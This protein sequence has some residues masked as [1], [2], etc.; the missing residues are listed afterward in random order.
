MN[1]GFLTICVDK[2]HDWHKIVF[3]VSVFLNFFVFVPLYFILR[4]CFVYKTL[5]ALGL[6]L[7]GISNILLKFI[8]A[9]ENFEVNLVCGSLAV[10]SVSFVYVNTI[11]QIFENSRNEIMIYESF[12]PTLKINCVIFIVLEISKL[13]YLAYLLVHD[14][15]FESIFLS[16]Q[17]GL[18]I[19]ITI[20]YE[21]NR[22]KL[23]LIEKIVEPFKNL[24]ARR[25][26][27]S[28]SYE[29]DQQV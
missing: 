9:N 26:F 23:I 8:I 4:R 2:L 25:S 19:M 16:S 1:I 27:S 7:V 17:I 12:E 24:M 21:L 20:I 14:P 28:F 22:R 6:V 5:V 10:L 3:H 11:S 15:L 29:N 18:I 13:I